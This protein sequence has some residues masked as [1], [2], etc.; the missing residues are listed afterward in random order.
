MFANFE[1]KIDFVPLSDLV[2]VDQNQRTE[3]KKLLKC[4]STLL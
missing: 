4:F 2:N 1:S 3:L